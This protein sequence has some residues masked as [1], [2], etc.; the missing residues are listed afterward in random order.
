MIDFVVQKKMLK[1]ESLKQAV[2]VLSSVS[3]LLIQKIY[4]WFC[5][6]K[7]I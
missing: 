2:S 6:Q 3:F 1:K 7:T 5:V 4:D